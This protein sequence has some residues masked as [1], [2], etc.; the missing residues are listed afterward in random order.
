MIKKSADAHKRG[1]GATKALRLIRLFVAP[2]C[3]LGVG[4]ALPIAV[5]A[6][7]PHGEMALTCTNPYSGATWRIKI[8]YDRR[9]V[10]ANPAEIDEATISWR[11]SANGWHYVLDRKSGKLTVTVASAT[12]GNFLY[13]SCKLAN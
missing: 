5:N 13:D 12:G 8:D 7:P 9:T 6:E 3:V 10:D 4:I 1:S 11:D 2:I